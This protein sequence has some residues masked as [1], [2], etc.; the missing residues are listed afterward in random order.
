MFE[1]SGPSFVTVISD[2][3]PNSD[4]KHPLSM[5]FMNFSCPCTPSTDSDKALE[6]YNALSQIVFN[7]LVIY[8]AMHTAYYLAILVTKTGLPQPV[9][10][11]RFYLLCPTKKLVKAIFYKWNPWQSFFVLIPISYLSTFIM[12]YSFPVYVIISRNHIYRIQV[13]S[14]SAIRFCWSWSV[15]QI[16]LL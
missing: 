1:R 10:F 4:E 7:L 8:F 6:S 14:D 15:H 2:Q 16:S 3:E 13:A 12:T 9:I 5:W 11:L